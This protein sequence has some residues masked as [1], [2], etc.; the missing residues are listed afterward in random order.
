MESKL[1]LSRCLCSGFQCQNR[2]N[3]RFRLSFIEVS[4]PLPFKRLLQRSHY[5]TWIKNLPRKQTPLH[6]KLFAPFFGATWCLEPE[7]HY[8]KHRKREVIK[9]AP[10]KCMWLDNR[11][12]NSRFLL[13]KL[14][15]R[16][17]TCYRQRFHGGFFQ[18]KNMLQWHSANVQKSSFALWRH[19]R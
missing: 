17:F 13:E 19:T 10:L 3:N 16:H 7:K 6:S 9:L 18:E 5:V 15:I 2:S 11:L 14:L 12:Q 1:K 4:R 8:P